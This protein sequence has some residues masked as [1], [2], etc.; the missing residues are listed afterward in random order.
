MSHDRFALLEHPLY[1]YGYRARLLNLLC[2]SRERIGPSRLYCMVSA[3]VTLVGDSGATPY[4]ILIQG[5]V[6]ASIGKAERKI[7]RVC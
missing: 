3:R 6:T 7:L 1:L 5:C 2:Q 4:L